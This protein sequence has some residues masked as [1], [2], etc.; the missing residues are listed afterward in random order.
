ML[1]TACSQHL[2]CPV[3][4]SCASSLWYVCVNVNISIFVCRKN[5]ACALV[6]RKTR[7]GYKVCTR[8]LH[9]NVSLLY[10]VYMAVEYKVIERPNPQDRTQKKYYASTNTT[11]KTT[12][13][14]LFKEVEQISALS[15]ADVQGVLYAL[16]EIIPRHL[17]DGKSVH[18]GYLGSFRIS[19]SSKGKAADVDMHS[20]KNARVAFTPS[21]E[22]SRLTEELHYKKIT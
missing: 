22:L 9:K 16:A 8:H 20:I 3:H 14:E 12:I 15:G 2:A 6:Y 18:L 13:K 21:H 11:G 17:A 4:Q 1:R 10:T 19:L 5:E 7:Q